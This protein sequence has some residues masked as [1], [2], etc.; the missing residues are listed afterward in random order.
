MGFEYVDPAK[1]GSFII[2]RTATVETA[3]LVISGQLEWWEV[4]AIR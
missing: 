1:D 4:P 2:S 3:G